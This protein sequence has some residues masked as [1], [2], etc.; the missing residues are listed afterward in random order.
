[1]NYNALDGTES[2][3]IQYVNGL[4]LTTTYCAHPLILFM[5]Y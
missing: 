1:M 5:A 3:G 2:I 4:R